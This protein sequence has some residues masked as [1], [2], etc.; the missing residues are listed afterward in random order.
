[1]GK[2]IEIFNVFKKERELAIPNNRLHNVRKSIRGKRNQRLLSGQPCLS[3]TICRRPSIRSACWNLK[4][5]EV[6]SKSVQTRKTL[7]K[8]FNRENASL[9]PPTKWISLCNKSIW[10]RIT[11]YETV[12]PRMVG[13]QTGLCVALHFTLSNVNESNDTTPFAWLARQAQ[14]NETK[15]NRHRRR[16]SIFLL[17]DVAPK[18]WRTIGR[19]DANNERPTSAVVRRNYL[20]I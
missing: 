16:T 20:K 12:K 4:T 13:G 19:R 5:L 17:A 10:K 14:N 6:F 1:M 18:K 7:R 15:T 2:S 3:C 11:F 8:I 9:P